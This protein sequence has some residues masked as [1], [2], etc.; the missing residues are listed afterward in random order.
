MNEEQLAALCSKVFKLRFDQDW[1]YAEEDER[2]TFLL[3][4]KA[5]F[6]EAASFIEGPYWDARRAVVSEPYSKPMHPEQWAELDAIE[7]VARWLKGHS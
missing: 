3:D 5:L 7:G 4:A 1:D 6:R 2:E